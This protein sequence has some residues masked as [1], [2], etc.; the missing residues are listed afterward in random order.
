MEL[1]ELVLGIVVSSGPALEQPLGAAHQ[2]ASPVLNLVRV[3]VVLLGQLREG[4]LPSHRG[5]GHLRLE[6]R[7][8]I[9]A[10]SSHL[11][12]LCAGFSDHDR[13][14]L[15]NRDPCPTDGV[16]LT[17][18][19]AA[20][21]AARALGSIGRPAESSA[22][23]STG[24]MPMKRILAAVIVGSLAGCGGGGGGGAM[25]PTAGGGAMTPTERA[26]T[27]TGA[28]PATETIADIGARTDGIIDRTDSLIVS[29]VHG[30]TNHADLPTFTLRAMCQ[31]VE[32]NFR[33]P[34]TGITV[35]LTA[36]D[37]EFAENLTTDFSLTKHG[38]N[39][40]RVTGTGLEAYGSWMEH[41]AFAVQ[42]ETGTVSIF[43]QNADY[44]TRYGIAG[45]DLTGSS[46]SGATAT[47][48]GL[49][50][51]TTPANGNLL[52]GDATLEYSLD[53]GTLGAAFTE[54]KDL[55]RNA[56][57]STDSVRFNDVPVATNGTYQAGSA[58][59][60]IQGGFY[61][62]DQAESTGVFEQSGIIGAFGAKKQ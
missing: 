46:P 41:S 47:W 60:R 19:R 1:L 42:T 17:D 2:P 37:L 10:L 28:S 9:P 31:D 56:A 16:H 33:E 40:L 11:L 29:T 34:Q 5:H 53:A 43:G 27:L 61:G 58:G 32:C 35:T 26:I 13:R 20:L 30:T 45:G 7:R 23:P 62:P 39:L 22:G 24:D 59:N 36:E 4:L 21:C 3:H 44:R 50:V 8:V 49:M 48:R 57:H 14:H 55:T 52:Q 15:R 38:I 51:G 54:I 18:G 25:T 6:R 12:V